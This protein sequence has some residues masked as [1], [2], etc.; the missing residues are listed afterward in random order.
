MK[1]VLSLVVMILT[2]SCIPEAKPKT[3]ESPS[4]VT[5]QPVV[6]EEVVT[7][8]TLADVTVWMM[9]T[10]KCSGNKNNALSEVK[11][12]MLARQ[13]DRILTTVGGDRRTQEAFI[14]LMCQESQYRTNLTSSAGAKGIAQMMPAT[15]QSEADELKMGKL[16]PDDLFDAEINILLGYTHFKRLVANYNGNLAKASA[17]YNGGPAGTTL[18]AMKNG[19]LGAQE[20][21]AYVRSMFDM[22][23]ERRIAKIEKIKSDAHGKAVSVTTQ[24]LTQ[25]QD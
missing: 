13:I 6:A 18:K 2:T 21:D 4:T 9:N 22:Q 5:E 17:A 25:S 11:K 14:F 12:T 24:P 1:F 8:E 19:G 3:P 7:E 23:E 15:A 16:T 10:P 20:T